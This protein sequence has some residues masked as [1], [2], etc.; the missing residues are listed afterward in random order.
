M[1]SIS[2]DGYRSSWIDRTI[3]DCIVRYCRGVD[4]LDAEEGKDITLDQVLLVATDKDTKVGTPTVKG[5][6]VT[7]KVVSH[8]KGDKVTTFKY[9]PRKRTRVKRGYRHSHTTLEIK[10]IK[11]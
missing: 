6:A 11:G 4:R 9:K 2:T 5:A 1:S 7:A 10:S 3:H 8:D